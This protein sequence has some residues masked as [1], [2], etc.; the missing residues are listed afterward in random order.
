MQTKIKIK[1][2]GFYYNAHAVLKNISMEI[3]KNTITAVTGPSGQGKSTLLFTL[4]RLWET[5]EGGKGDRPD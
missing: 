1:N 3:A 5:M 2:L 4:N